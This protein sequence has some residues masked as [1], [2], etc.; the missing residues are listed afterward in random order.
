MVILISAAIL[1]P[2]F[3]LDLVGLTLIYPDAGQALL[4]RNPIQWLY[5]FDLVGFGL[6]Y[7]DWWLVQTDRFHFPLSDFRFY[8]ELLQRTVTKFD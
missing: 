1:V 4:Q 5:F 3:Y 8:K 7:P 6:I 2:A